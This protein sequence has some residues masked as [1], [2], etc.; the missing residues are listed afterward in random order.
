MAGGLRGSDRLKQTIHGQSETRY[1]EDM[2]L[3]AK[4]LIGLAV[5]A[6]VFVIGAWWV[7]SGA[8]LP[9]IPPSRTAAPEGFD[10]SEYQILTEVPSSKQV[11]MRDLNDLGEPFEFYAIP[12]IKVTYFILI[13]PDGTRRM[14]FLNAE[15]T[16]IADIT[17][18]PAMFPMGRFLVAPGGFHE[19]SAQGVSSRQPMVEV[20]VSS[21]AEL[22][23]MIAQSSHYRTFSVSELSADDPARDSDGQVHVM[24]RD[25]VWTQIVTDDQSY[26]DWKGAPFHDLD[27]DHRIARATT[28]D[29]APTVFGGRYRVE[30]THFDQ[31]EFLP[32]RNPA[33]GSPTATVRPAQWIGTGYYT[34]F[35]GNAPVLRFR[36]ENDREL[37][38]SNASSQLSV[39]GGVGLDFVVLD[40]R[41]HSGRRHLI[42]LR[43]P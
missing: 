22:E 29:S 23:A 4:I 7:L 36:I 15:G 13:Q 35:A 8:P 14:L 3:L 9:A 34:V 1:R 30:L 16:E 11:E 12:D 41:D 31:Q 27:V 33:M 40:P 18:A 28:P 5:C 42:V 26:F 20:T 39:H 43:A 32:R 10:P 17:V 19:V 37:I 25:G 24:R 21:T 2:T 6:I 38:S